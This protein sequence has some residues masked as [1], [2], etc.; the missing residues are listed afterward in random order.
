[1]KG[2][3]KRMSGRLRVQIVNW[4]PKYY[5]LGNLLFQFNEHVNWNID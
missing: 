3:A 5:D 2:Y 4:N 1:M